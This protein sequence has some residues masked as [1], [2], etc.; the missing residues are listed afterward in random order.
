MEL[1]GAPRAL[2]PSGR[3]SATNIHEKS[4]GQKSGS[5]EDDAGTPP[6]SFETSPARWV[7]RCHLKIGGQEG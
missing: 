3:P 6:Y 2:A 1:S 5:R 4:V 7:L